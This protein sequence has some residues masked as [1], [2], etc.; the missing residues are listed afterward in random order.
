MVLRCI[1]S[2][3]TT[4]SST[5]ASAMH[6]KGH[7]GLKSVFWRKFR[8]RKAGSTSTVKKKRLTGTHDE[9]VVVVVGRGRKMDVE[10]TT[11]TQQ[12]STLLP[13][14]PTT[15]G[16]AVSCCSAFG[17]LLLSR[18]K[19]GD[20]DAFRRFLTASDETKNWER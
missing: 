15:T 10:I 13:Q 2:C 20:D 12:P 11:L 17:I 4:P 5:A 14:P 3:T 8:K 6:H 16:I 9:E 18:H 1:T 19:S 7:S